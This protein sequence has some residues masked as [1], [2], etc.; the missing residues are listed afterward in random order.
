MGKLFT[1]SSDGN[2]V[3]ANYN[4]ECTYALSTEIKYEYTFSVVSSC[5]ILIF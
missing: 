1:A 2:K 3:I 4:N 5:I